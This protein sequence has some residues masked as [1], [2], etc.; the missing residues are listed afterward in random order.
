MHST[1]N[2]LNTS[3]NADILKWIELSRQNE[4]EIQEI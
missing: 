2:E 1:R 4:D 3:L